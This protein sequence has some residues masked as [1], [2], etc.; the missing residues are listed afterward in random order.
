MQLNGLNQVLL[1]H[2]GLSD[3][4]MHVC[5]VSLQNNPVMSEFT[6]EGSAL[7]LATGS[8]FSKVCTAQSTKNETTVAGQASLPQAN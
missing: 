3:S 4:R 8:V 1:Y 2:G 5:T 6:V 7:L